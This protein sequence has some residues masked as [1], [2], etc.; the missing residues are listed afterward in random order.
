MSEHVHAAGT[1]VEGVATVKDGDALIVA[2]RVFVSVGKARQ[3]L[4]SIERAMRDVC[5]RPPTSKKPANRPHGSLG[6][7]AA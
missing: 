3:S 4:D 2:G 7:T 1:D 5:L 6:W